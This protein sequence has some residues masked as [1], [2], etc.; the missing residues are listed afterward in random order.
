MYLAAIAGI[1]EEMNEAARVDGASRMQIIWNITIPSILPTYFVLV[2]PGKEKKHHKRAVA[3]ATA[4]LKVAL[5]RL[6]IYFC[7]GPTY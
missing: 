5:T 1:D 6:F 3:Y 2:M 4:L 7:S